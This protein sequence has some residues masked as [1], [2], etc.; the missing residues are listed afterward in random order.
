MHMYN[1]QEIARI[2][3]LFFAPTYGIMLEAVAGSKHLAYK[4]FLIEVQYI[5]MRFFEDFSY[6]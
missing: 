2:P 1:K 5:V 3:A 6:V 4:L